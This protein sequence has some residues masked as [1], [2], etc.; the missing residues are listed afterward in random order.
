MAG[1]RKDFLSLSV[2]PG[3]DDSRTESALV[4]DVSIMFKSL[5]S[6]L[7]SVTTFSEFVPRT[8]PAFLSSYLSFIL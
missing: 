4:M 2:T 1:D 5:E 3:Y 6:T 8:D 7:L